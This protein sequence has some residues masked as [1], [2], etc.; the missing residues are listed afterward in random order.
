MILLLAG[1]WQ[2]FIVIYRKDHISS[3]IQNHVLNSDEDGP[4]F[5]S[6]LFQALL[7][8]FAFMRLQGVILEQSRKTGS[9]T[10]LSCTLK[11]VNN[12][13]P[14]VHKKRQRGT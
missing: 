11:E 4:H 9:V 1:N 3:A 10:A 13:S 8:G 7:L 2:V 14:N 6:L 5:V 12:L